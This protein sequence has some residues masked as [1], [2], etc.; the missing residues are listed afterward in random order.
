[1]S[2][3]VTERGRVSVSKVDS[4]NA[5]MPI[6]VSWEG[7]ASSSWKVIVFSEAPLKASSCRVVTLAGTQTLSRSRPPKTRPPISVTDSGITTS[8]SAPR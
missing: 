1:M 8:L 5:W 4:E 3:S 2:I 6:H 7:W